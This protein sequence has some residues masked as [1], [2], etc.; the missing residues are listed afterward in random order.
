MIK[1]MLY[2]ITDDEA[3][4]I[5]HKNGIFKVRLFALIAGKIMV[6]K[7]L[8]SHRDTMYTLSGNEYAR[9]MYWQLSRY[10]DDKGEHENDG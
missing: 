4:F 1:N 9:S 7:Y 2:M 8:K 10:H 6:N 3:K 5:V